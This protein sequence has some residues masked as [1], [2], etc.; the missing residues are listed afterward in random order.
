MP[1]SARREFKRL[2]SI[3]V[4]LVTAINRGSWERPAM[5]VGKEAEVLYLPW[6]VRF[7]RND[8]A[9]VASSTWSE[10]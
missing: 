3:G 7:P 4:C 8:E 9:L 2:P 6:V 5:S 10:W 1:W